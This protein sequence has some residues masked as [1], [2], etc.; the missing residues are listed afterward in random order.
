MMAVAWALISTEAIKLRRTVAVWLAVAAP[1]L[2]ILIELAAVFG[3]T[4]PPRGTT[5]A[6][7]RLLLQPGWTSWFG[8]CLPMLIAFEA[9]CLAN[10]ENNGKQ[11]KQLF[12][13]PIPRW[14]VYATK[15]L[16]CGLLVGASFVVAVLGFAGDV[17]SY[18]VVYGLHMASAIPWPEILTTAGK[19]YVA[20]WLLIVIQS[21]LGAR[22]AGLAS[23]VGIGFAGLVLGFVVLLIGEGAVSS[24]YPW[25]LPLRTFL[26][27][28]G[29]LHKTMLP[30]VFGCAGAVVF[31]TIACWDLARRRDFEKA[32][33]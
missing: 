6:Q 7:W 12:A 10:L 32:W 23:P 33:N 30:A 29:D 5:S 24:W 28:P 4:T 20:S 18:S 19:A 21:W 15:M 8:F 9:A 17:L 1:A 22:F 16:F 27:A 2:A 14:S 11:W 25:L 26:A 3:R 31:G 13:F